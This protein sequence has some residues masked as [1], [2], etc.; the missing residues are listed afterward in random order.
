MALLKEELLQNTVCRLSQFEY[1]LLAQKAAVYGETE[2]CA[3]R[4]EA[5]VNQ[6]GIPLL[7]KMTTDHLVAI[8]LY[9]NHPVLCPLTFMLSL[10][11]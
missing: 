10:S 1:E 5:G 9:C 6:F 11:L 3:E 8:L 4:I 7:A 2:H